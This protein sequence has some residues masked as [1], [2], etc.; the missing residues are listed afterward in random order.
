MPVSLLNLAWH[1]F[2]WPPVESLARGTFDVAHSLHPL[3]MPTRKAAQIV[4]IHD[5]DFLTHP[6][7]TRAEVRRDY[8][9]LARAHAHRADHIIVVSE[10]TAREVER[11]FEVPRTRMSVCPSGA[12]D[13]RPRTAAPADGYVL[14]LGTLEPR[15][16]I[17]G[18]LDAYEQLALRRRDLPRLVL[19]GRATE[20]ARPWLDRLD[21][22]PLRGLVE[23]VGYVE[24][25]ARRT[26]YEGARLLVQPSF[27]EG[28]GLPVLEAMTLGIPVVAS[29][30]G[31]LPEVLG[32]AGPLVDPRDSEALAAAIEH[33]I[34][35]AASAADST[36]RGLQRA[37]AF[38]WDR[39]AV[40]VRDA[41]RKAIEHRQCAS[42]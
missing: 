39:T 24:S 38:R 42:A 40:L 8:P 22:Q 7:R 20:Q 6:E 28:F 36:A 23:H 33:A 35:D 12:P 5:L 9:A 19:A 34:Y 13:W 25:S 31:A 11:Q 26:L 1:R 4:T 14:F 17:G 15:K 29:N 27:E 3:L 37:A 10:F 16:N 2:G 41:Y 21:R 18:L 30:A 32:D